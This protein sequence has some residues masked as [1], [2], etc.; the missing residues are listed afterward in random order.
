MSTAHLQ[1]LE[2]RTLMSASAAV[3]PAVAVDRL[4][5]KADLLQ[6]RADA[7]AGTAALLR[8]VTAFKGEHLAAATTVTPLV[9]ELRTDVKSMQLTLTGD[10]LTESQAVLGDELVIVTDIRHALA[11]RGTATALAADKAA[12]LTERAKLQTD[13]VA[14]L[15][16]RIA[17]RTAATTTIFNDVQ[18]IEAAAATDPNATA[19]LRAS[20]QQFGTDRT[21]KLA[22]LTADLTKLGADRTTLAADLMTA[23]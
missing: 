21:A 6:F 10:R 9:S 15:N 17:A 4:V 3:S 14:G 7:T 22:T 19:A 23:A 18:A 20:I 5:V 8:D 13:E 1:S 11:D 2:S 12:V 16:S